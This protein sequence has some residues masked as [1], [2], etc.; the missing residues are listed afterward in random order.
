VST[1]AG[2]GLAVDRHALQRAFSRASTRYDAAATLQAEVRAELHERLGFFTLD[3][4]RVL[5]AGCGTGEGTIALRRRYRRAQVLGL[6]LA[7]GMLRVARARG[8]PWQRPPVVCADVHSLPLPDASLDLV[9]SNL[10]LQ[11]CD[12]LPRA[13]AQ[14][15]RA[16]RPG[17]LLLFSTFGSETLLELRAS[18]AEA[19]ESAHVSPFVDMPSL[20]HALGSAGFSEP[21][22]DRELR[23]QRHASVRALMDSIRAIGAGNALATRRRTLTGPRR[24]QR[25]QAAYEAQR[26][27]A[28][29]PASWEILYGAAFSGGDGGAGTPPGE[30]HVP[31]AALRPLRSRTD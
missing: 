14:L 21:V 9:V 10:M 30:A 20:G 18:W 11:W 1:A 3:P 16:L 28:G 17:G 27:P 23:V 7:P 29:L 8:W 22:L 19:D 4:R 13:F 12:D 24:L 5:D 26:T 31:L 6:D 2:A 25:M 15:R